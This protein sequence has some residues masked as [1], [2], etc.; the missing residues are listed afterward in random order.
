MSTFAYV[1]IPVI[2]AMWSLIGFLV[3]TAFKAE[4]LG[5]DF[6]APAGIAAFASFL[7][8]GPFCVVV[9][10]ALLLRA[11]FLSHTRPML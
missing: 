2:L 11:I 5:E 9:W 7:F 8:C 3:W 4:R 10:Y 1:I 6:F